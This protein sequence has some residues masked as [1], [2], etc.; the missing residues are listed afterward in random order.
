MVAND[1][2]AQLSYKGYME[3]ATR[4][5]WLEDGASMLPPDMLIPFG[6]GG[7]LFLL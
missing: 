5:N 7:E 2:Y 1:F 3:R 6:D 4:E